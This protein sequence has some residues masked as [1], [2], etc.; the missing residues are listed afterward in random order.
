M[1]DDKNLTDEINDIL[2]DVENEVDEIIEASDD[3]PQA[4]ASVGDSAEMEVVKAKA[5]E[6][7]GITP[8]EDEQ[9]VRV[10]INEG[11]A[12]DAKDVTIG[13]NGRVIQIQRGVEV[14]IPKPYLEVLQN[15]KVAK[16]VQ[17][18]EGRHELRHKPRF[19]FQVLGDA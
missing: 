6:R 4:E 10:I 19:S 8:P 5:P 1:S 3:V 12:S 15:A 17:V 9:R 11:D 7:T 2:D 16:L 14:S 18:A 13:V